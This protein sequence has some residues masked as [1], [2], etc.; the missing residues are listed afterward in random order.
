MEASSKNSSQ[1]FAQLLTAALA[2]PAGSALAESPPE[3]ASIKLMY[4]D[5]EDW[6][7]GG[8]DRMH[9]KSPMIWF[10]TPIADSWAVEGTLQLD[11]MSGASP[12][13]LDSLSGA[14]ELG[15]KD[16]RQWADVRVTK[17]FERFSLS[18]GGAVSTEDDY[19]SRSGSLEGRWW[20]EDKNTTVSFGISP[21]FD[22][23]TSTNNTDLI[24]R[25][26]AIT[27]LLGVTQVLSPNALLQ[28]NFSYANG[29]GYHSDP[30]KFFDKRPEGRDQFAWLTRHNYF[31][32][33][34]DAALHTDYR[35]YWDSW[36]VRSHTLEMKWYQ[37]IGEHFMIRP[38]VRYYSQDSAEF[39][40]TEFP[41]QEDGAIYSPDQRL[42]SYG[43]F[44]YGLKL[45]YSLGEHVSLN[46]LVQFIEQ[47][48]SWKLFGSGD[49]DLKHYKARYTG[50]G[51]TAKF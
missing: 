17:Y 41:P 13:Y 26:R 48:G 50:V 11:D 21:D 4:F 22:R 15:I 25:R 32:E 30:Y 1:L 3:S 42:A 18:L 44:S 34:A 36:S 29:A 16:R 5:Y 6:Q 23:I 38:G 51:V 9:I 45:E 8:Q 20:S 12:Q 43:S 19:I 47:R 33:A 28:S 46:A 49:E 10:A 37:P 39:F 24:E 7:E 2:I 31:V 40:S 35:Y 14:S 27:Y